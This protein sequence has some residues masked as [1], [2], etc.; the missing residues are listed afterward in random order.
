MIVARVAA[1]FMLIAGSLSFPESA[2]AANGQC[3]WEGGA[4]A[5][6]YGY[7]KNE[8]CI[9][10]GGL[11]ECV[12]PV[13]RP[14][15]SPGIE[16]D[17]DG[18]HWKFLGCGSGSNT[19]YQSKWCQ[20]A[21]G[22]WTANLQC[23]GLS[24]SFPG[25]NPA[26][27]NNEGLML[28]TAD[29]FV[30]ALHGACTVNPGS[31]TGWGFNNTGDQV[32]WSGAPLTK[33]GT[34]IDDYRRRT[35]QVGGACTPSTSTVVLRRVRSVSCP[36]HY[37]TRI[38]PNG[39]LHCYRPAEGICPINN[40]VAPI[41]GEKTL[42]EVDYRGA[43]A[44]GLE[45]AR[46]YRSLGYFRLS[47]APVEREKAHHYW[48]HSYQRR[49]YPMANNA[50]LLAV[51]QEDD[52]KL[53]HF[54]TSGEEIL[55]KD[56]AAA[57]LQSLGAGGWTIRHRDDRIETYDSSG[58]L[59]A[60]TTR[61]GVATS[62]AYDGS[63]RLSVVS[64]SFGNSL[65][66]QYDGSGRLIGFQHP[67]GAVQYTNDPATGRLTTVTYPDATTRSYSYLDPRNRFLIT[68]IVNEAG[69]L[70]ASYEYDDRGRVVLTERANGVNRYQY[71]YGSGGTSTTVTNPLGASQTYAMAN[72]A[73]VHKPT[74]FPAGC[75][76][77]GTDQSLIYDDKGNVSV[78]RDFRGYATKY[79][80]DLTRNLET[81]RTEGMNGI[82]NP[83]NPSAT[84]SSRT[85][86]TQWHPNYRLPTQITVYTGATATG[87]P[88]RRTNYTHDASGNVLTRTITDTTV[89]PNVSRTWTYT[90]NSYGQVL[91]ENGPRTDVSDVTTYTYHSCT[92]GFHCGQLETV[93]NPLG[94]VTT[95]NSYNAH[96]QPTQIT[97][98]NGL[99]TSM[100]YD[101]RQRLSDLCQGGTLPGC[102]GGE[103]THFDYWP[104][105]SLKKATNPDG[106]FIEYQYDAAGRLVQVSD[107]SMNRI[108]YALD[109]MGN[110]TAENTID[111]SNLLRRT[112]TRV[113]NNLSRL[114]KD[115]GAAGTAA[116][117]TV[118][119]YD[120]SGNQTTTNA[121]L[122]RNSTNVYDELDRLKQITDPAS[123]I[124]RFAY[125]ANDNLTSVTDPRNLITSYT[126]TGFGD[127][128]TTLSPDTGLT[129]NT[130]DSGGNLDTSTDSR[131]A[132]A[133]YA[134]DAL[135]RP[136]SVA[137]TKSGVTD[138][139]IT[140]GYDAGTNQKGLLT[141]A[142][143]ANHVLAWTYDAKGRVTGKGQTVGGVTLAIGYGYN[144]A[145]QL[146][147]VTL[148]SGNVVSFG[149]NTNGQVSGLTL[150]GS[151]TLLN[152]ITYD[153][154]GPITGW[155][156]GN[157]TAASRGFDT[158]GK[159]TQVD[160]ANGASLK[161]YGYDDAFRITSITDAA[162]GA[163][164]WTYGYD[165]LDRLNSATTTGTTQGW[166]YDANGNRLTQTGSTPSTY[167]NSPSSNRVSSIS[168][169]LPRSYAY[170]NAGNT[171]SY[172]TATFTYNHRGRMATA[173][174]A[175]T[176]ATYTYNALGQR[177]RRATSSIT[178]V[179]VYDEA[180]HLVGEYT[181]AGGLIQE[182][183]WLGDMP[184]ATLRPNGAGGVDVFYVH[185][186]HLNTPR[187]VTDSSNNIRWR[188]DSDPFG[189][190]APNENP[191]GLGTFVYNLRFPGQQYDAVV[192][193]HYNYFRDYDPAVGRY[194]ES[195]PIGLKG[196]LDTY[197]YVGGDPLS[198]VD[199]LGLVPGAGPKPARSSRGASGS[200]AA[201][202]S[203]T[204]SG[205]GV[206]N[207][208]TG[209]TPQDWVCSSGA[210]PLNHSACQKK[211]CIAHDKC[212][213]RYGCNASSWI[214][215]FIHLGPPFELGCQK[216]NREVVEC[217]AKN[218]G[219]NDNPPCESCVKPQEY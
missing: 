128:K 42:V 123:G 201:G 175:G 18:E 32:C 47:S 95:Y 59:S 37:F 63:G 167:T 16:A 104:T 171:L 116:V 9:G 219:R 50:E 15:N 28:S 161:N 102:V 209:F 113:F 5:P 49:L 107:G 186:D 137:F 54:N 73:G 176:T 196:G 35:Y 13:T 30:S 74:S 142:S 45:F 173:T 44:G 76:S 150:N 155:T 27:A 212:Y 40:P 88:T 14:Y 119:G 69:V 24:P 131:G 204:W 206:G 60:I 118:Y 208:W 52:G 7:C 140:F 67:G 17:T 148:P 218:V 195:D 149:Y 58:L 72:V 64:D 31:D 130:Y 93:T 170:D 205:R 97:S 78:R 157:G 103:L 214:T 62:L 80:Y 55:N 162:N 135:N 192:G 57:H 39:D 163:L 145:G 86:T 144:A 146:G 100:A 188:W 19:Y 99:V 98:A 122:G 217:I 41:S 156:W 174:N 111:P 92:S 178:T 147:N 10:N 82:T 23:Q 21:G 48:R 139:T 75:S 38:K 101:L 71:S 197:G 87:T 124:T 94:H 194:V 1:C 36:N 172:G 190:T 12:T 138:Q 56:G 106:S 110:R 66:L 153:P 11:A 179:Y 79:S 200:W 34:L 154:F 53:R 132:V 85:I 136:T 89:T 158:D 83:W 166:T 105:G 168:G 77:C 114:W 117:T 4:G 120:G 91:T 129:T 213:Q 121:P 126:Y 164:S 152:N 165:T 199:P 81:S 90:Y 125:D 20:A 160:N 22:T 187:L 203:G 3:R 108:V 198:L 46:H 51:L 210:A 112:R 216:C 43:G 26:N 181:A 182:T 8:D 33:N 115:I 65:T 2:P 29:A 70:F 184:I 202:A 84:T 96:G 151:T 191:S 180:G 68:G 61:A 183:V 211:C 141:S 6:L 134:H 193:L 169:S 127:L 109:A 207:V 177:I 159:I 143:D 25:G 185:T 189:T 215:S 133:D